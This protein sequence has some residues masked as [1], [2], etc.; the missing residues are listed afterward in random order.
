M[1]R[2][3]GVHGAFMGLSAPN[4]E[5]TKRPAPTL[6][7][8]K[9]TKQKKSPCFV[10]KTPYIQHWQYFKPQT[11]TKQKPNKFIQIHTNSYK[12]KHVW[13]KHQT[14]PPPQAGQG[15]CTRVKSTAYN[16]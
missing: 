3:L 12:S 4:P 5:Q 13:L 10:L 16:G 15:A 2:N 7:S 14:T 1:V 8:V 9:Q 6:S 11:K